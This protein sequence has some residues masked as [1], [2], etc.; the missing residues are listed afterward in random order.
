MRPL[1]DVAMQDSDQAFGGAG[2]AGI[3]F[4]IAA[5]Y[6]EADFAVDDFDE[7]AVDGTA[8]SGDLLQD[9]GAFAFFLDG[10]TDALQLTLQAI[11]PGEQLLF[12]GGGMG[13]GIPS[14]TYYT[15][16]SI[17]VSLLQAVH[18]F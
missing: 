11:D 18:S 14:L 13:H 3:D 16:Y 5:E 15:Q 2:F 7:Q 8:A 4:R 17:T 6:V 9:I 12:F 10:S 1:F